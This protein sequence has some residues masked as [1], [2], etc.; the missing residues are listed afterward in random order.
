MGHWISGHFIVVWYGWSRGAE[1]RRGL[2]V[3]YGSARA[4]VV[5]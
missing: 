4:V 1:R 2:Y 5:I 3:T